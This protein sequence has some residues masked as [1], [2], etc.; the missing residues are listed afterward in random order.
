MGL[1]KWFH[2]DYRYPRKSTFSHSWKQNLMTVP[3]CDGAIFL[4]ASFASSDATISARWIRVPSRNYPSAIKHGLL[5]NPT[6]YIDVLHD[7]RMNTSIYRGRDFQLHP[8][9]AGSIWVKL[10]GKV[11]MAC[12]TPMFSS[13]GTKDPASNHRCTGKLTFPSQK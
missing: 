11:H 5:E 9:M 7:F 8:T 4:A 3:V 10:Y 2:W 1:W 12:Q 13:T 6:F